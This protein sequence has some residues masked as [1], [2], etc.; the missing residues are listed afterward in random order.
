MKQCLNFDLLEMQQSIMISSESFVVTLINLTFDHH[1]FPGG[2]QRVLWHIK[3]TDW[4]DPGGQCGRGGWSVCLQEL[5]VN[6]E[7]GCALFAHE[8][9]PLPW[10]F[11]CL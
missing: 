3:Q 9:G 2:N 5:D 8:S 6:S 11:C 4:V 10:Q 7:C 1:M